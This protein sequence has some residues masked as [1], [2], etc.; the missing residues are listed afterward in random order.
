MCK[1]DYNPNVSF[2]LKMYE[3][4]IGYLIILLMILILELIAL[5]IS[6][7]GTIM[8]TKPRKFLEQIIY[9]RLGLYQL[10]NDYIQKKIFIFSYI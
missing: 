7:R 2:S 10:N 6:C 4:H 1:I 8:N 9:S 3:Y 5:I